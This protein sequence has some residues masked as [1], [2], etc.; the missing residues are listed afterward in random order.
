MRQFLSPER[1]A[2][3]RRLCSECVSLSA[4]VLMTLASALAQFEARAGIITQSINPGE[5]AMAAWSD[6]NSNRVLGTA[7]STDLDRDGVVQFTIPTDAQDRPGLMVALCWPG[8]FSAGIADVAIQGTQSFVAP[9][10]VFEPFRFTGF[11]AQDM[12]T[13]LVA[14]IVIEQL[15]AD[16]GADALFD[17]GQ[18]LSID[19][20][21]VSGTSAIVFR[22]ASTLSADPAIRIFELL[23]RRRINALPY[24]TGKAIVQSAGLDSTTGVDT[25]API[26]A[27]STVSLLGIGVYALILSGG[28]R[29]RR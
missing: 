29:R 18:L 16:G 6:V 12:G 7:R 20:G 21:S 5:T 15:I 10:S 2:L 9:F 28:L 13:R 27:P 26:S 11:S 3:A 8:P 19:R 1:M 22:D 17:P 14:Q 25:F 23:D 24:F 4:A